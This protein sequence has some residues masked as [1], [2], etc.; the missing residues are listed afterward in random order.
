MWSWKPIGP[1]IEPSPRRV[2]RTGSGALPRSRLARRAHSRGATQAEG[3]NLRRALQAKDRSRRIK[4]RR[5]SVFCV[6]A[7]R[8]TQMIGSGRNRISPA[9][10]GETLGEACACAA[11]R[12]HRGIA[13]EQS[14]KKNLRALGGRSN[15]LLATQSQPQ[16]GTAQSL[17]CSTTQRGAVGDA[18][19]VAPLWNRPAR[20]MD[21]ARSDALR[22]E[23]RERTAGEPLRGRCMD[24]AAQARAAI[25]PSSWRRRSS[26][27]DARRCPT[28]GSS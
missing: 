21:A 11:L 19:R 13:H 15:G 25:R 1:N 2:S 20:R 6:C 10:L 17:R 14:S 9:R 26:T 28:T 7:S 5:R 4:A 16:E 23:V 22:P 12:S 27:G 24:A 3:K 18:A 8:R